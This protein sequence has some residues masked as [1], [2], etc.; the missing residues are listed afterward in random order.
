L[1][2]IVCALAASSLGGCG[3]ISQKLGET[4]ADNPKLGLPAGTPERPAAVSAFPA[5]HDMPP[6]RPAG[7]NSQEQI[8]MEED[9]MAARDRQ[10]ALVGQTPSPRPSSYTSTPTT[11]TPPKVLLPTA[12]KKPAQDKPAAPPSSQSIY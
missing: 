1:V 11:P 2:A 12:T 6:P 9:L 3:S 10:Q 5:V 7:L 8:K 4:V